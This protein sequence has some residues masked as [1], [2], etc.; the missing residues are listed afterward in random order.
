MNLALQGN[1]DRFTLPEIFQLLAMGRKSGTLGI[2]REDSIV[3]VYFKDG[4]IIYGYGPR[5]TYHL[6]QLLKDRGVLT[7]EQLEQAIRVQSHDDNS[8]RLGAI[9]ISRGFIDRSDLESA[10][11]QQVDELLYS[12]L[13]WE[14]GSFKFYE[15]Q[16][17][18]D[19]EITVNVSVE[20]VI[21]E[22]LRRLDERNMAQE[23]LGDSNMVYMLAVTEAER[24]RDVAL[25]GAEWNVMTLVNGYRTVNE[26]VAASPMGQDETLRVMAQLKL[27]GMIAPA[28][29]LQ[30]PPSA[31]L[32]GQINRLARLFED[33]LTEKTTSR[34][35][36]NMLKTTSMEQNS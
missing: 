11:R 12:L 17:P 19:E 31:E 16:Y 22:G 10:V 28:M 21:L 9:L 32:D 8:H 14:S 1:I 15:N 5:Q 13:A 34:L 25:R 18:T 29:N 6:G 26:I 30:S 23:A 35:D 7:A 3:M 2:Q 36:P 20:N 24:L 27:A 33:Y 4:S